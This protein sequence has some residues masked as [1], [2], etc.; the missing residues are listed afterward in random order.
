MELFRE[1]RSLC[2]VGSSELLD[3]GVNDPRSGF[4]SE[5][6]PSAF[7]VKCSVKINEDHPHENKQRPFIQRLLLHRSLPHHL[8]LPEIQR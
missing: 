4:S 5:P 7:K 3:S 2:G 6:F 8:H 1:H